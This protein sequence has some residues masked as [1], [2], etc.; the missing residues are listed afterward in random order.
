[1]VAEATPLA[2]L[3]CVIRLSAVMFSPSA[4]TVVERSELSFC[5]NS[6]KESI[7]LLT[8]P[9]WNPVIISLTPDVAV[10]QD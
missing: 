4:N 10:I 8:K 2:Y 6:N 3:V 1:M 9:A 5:N 7:V